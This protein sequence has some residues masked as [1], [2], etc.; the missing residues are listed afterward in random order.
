[1]A[2]TW[3]SSA[4]SIL[5]T[6]SAGW[7]NYT[8]RQI[9]DGAQLLVRGE[10]IRVT[11]TA[12]AGN[13]VTINSAYLGERAGT[14]GFAGTPLPITVSGSSVFTIPAGT[15][16]TSDAI[17]FDST[18]ISALVISY[19]SASTGTYAARNSKPGW[20][21]W[22]KGGGNDAATPNASGYGGWSVNAITV[23]LVEVGT[24][25]APPEAPVR[26]T[27]SPILV[28]DSGAKK[29]RVTQTPV[30]VIDSSPKRL[31]V[32]QTPVLILSVP[33]YPVR[34]TQ[35]PVIV[36]SQN[37]PLAEVK[38]LVP[39]EPVFEKWEWNTAI[40]V[41]VSG[42]E[43]R[44]KLRKYPRLILDIELS[45]LDNETRLNVENFLYR[46]IGN[47]IKYPLYQ[48]YFSV[49]ASSDPGSSILSIEEGHGISI[50][51]EV[52]IYYSSQEKDV[53]YKVSGVGSDFIV[54]S[55]PLSEKVHLCDTVSL[56]DHFK[57]ENEPDFSTESVHGGFS[58]SL[59]RTKSKQIS[60][61][62]FAEVGS[63]LDGKALL[64]RV[65]LAG[66]DNL[67]TS[68]SIWQDNL[69]ADPSP[70][71]RRTPIRISENHIFKAAKKELVYWDSF[72]NLISGRL[73]SFYL[74]SVFN[75]FPLA[76]VPSSASHTLVSS[77]V[78]SFYYLK[79]GSPTRYIKWLAVF[80]GE[81][82]SYIKINDV[83]L[84]YDEDGNPSLLRLFLGSAVGPGAITKICPV[85]CVRLS[86]DV[87][88]YQHSSTDCLISFSTITVNE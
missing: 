26:V 20:G 1:M 66:K 60:S 21:I 17:P 41:S 18:G 28:L 75:S 8:V 51:D 22:Y 77:N 86:D 69:I 42:K 65:E 53:F 29:A 15:T 83:S 27:Q 6:T 36:A 58:F 43:R 54:L 11:F 57:I 52:S 49:K 13:N 78:E 32:T 76:E 12:P 38:P 70:K 74:L 82:I 73:N 5:N 50:G 81:Q 67:F 72:F 88:E 85:F 24:S 31:R 62:N 64:D 33:T 40:S 3:Y 10:Y 7:S 34:V 2:I 35:T 63:I 16:L 84:V 87:V 4:A 68:N 55:V 19:Y 39:D 44:S 25:E 61:I 30:L 23:S 79:P 37:K 45:W 9:I 14:Y 46:T 48:R 71:K 80:K 47:I 59:T 56:L